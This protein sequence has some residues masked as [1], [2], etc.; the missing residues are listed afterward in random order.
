MGQGHRVPAWNAVKTVKI[1]AL[2]LWFNSLILSE[3]S[4]SN[5][6]ANLNRQ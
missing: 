2:K 1:A 4:D 5:L 3:I 6:G